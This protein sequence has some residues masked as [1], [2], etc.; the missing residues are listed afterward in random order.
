[1]KKRVISI[2]MAAATTVSLL[3]GCGS[4]QPADSG[5]TQ[6]AQKEETQ[7]ADSGDAAEATSDQPSKYQTTYGSKQFDNVTITVELFDRSNAPDGSTITDNKWT[8]YVN[9]QMNKVG[10]NVEFVPVPRWDEVTKM[11]AMVA[12]QTAPDLTL[13]Y[14]YA[15]AEDYFNQGG[16]W[17]LSEFVDGADQA[18]NM[19]KY[20]GT[21]VIDIGRK[22]SGELYGIVAKRA[23][24]AKSNYFIRK[25]WLDKLGLGIPTNPDE[26]YTALDKMVHENPD[27]MKGVSGA[28]IWNGWNLKQVFSKIAND[29]VKVNICGGGEDV[30]QDYYDPGMYDYYQYLNK[31]YNAGI[32]HQEYYNLAED[33]FKSEIVTGNLGFC[34]YSVNGNVDVLRG[35][36]LK[37]L[38][39]NVSDADFVSIPQFKNVNDGNV[40]SA[41]YGAGGLIAFCPKTASEE[42]VEA[43]MTYLDWMCTEEGGFVLYHGFEGEHYSMTDGVPVV[44][45]AEYNSQDKDW[46][47]TD[48]FIVGNQGYFETVEDFNKCTSKEAPGFEDYVIQNYEYALEGTLNHDASYTSPSTAD[49]ITDLNIAKDDYQVKMITCAPEEFDDMYN[50]YMDELKDIGID[51]IIQEREEYY[52][53]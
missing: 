29:P 16:T 1:M 31:L 24:T 44:K 38:K 37:T 25:D 4:T 42:V 23:T 21:D 26:L 32:L 51:T 8:K 19:K 41:A 39:E 15:Y 9:E 12:S 49:L 22:E 33:D 14:T 13:T 28:I 20:L 7:S 53:K 47:R 17:D 27:G 48:I 35:S 5:A 52:N 3:A 18:L 46:I 11:Q 50:E 40:Y 36:L 45:D 34:E 2:L 43:C 6:D 30:I 10:I